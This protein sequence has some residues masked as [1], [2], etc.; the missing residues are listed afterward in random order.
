VHRIAGVHKDFCTDF[1]VC[2]VRPSVW[3]SVCGLEKEHVFETRNLKFVFSRFS[4]PRFVVTLHLNLKMMASD[5]VPPPEGVAHAV[6]AHTS[7]IA[8]VPLRL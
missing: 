3:Y 2:V 8:Q 6:A 1:S 7:R 4:N 5:E